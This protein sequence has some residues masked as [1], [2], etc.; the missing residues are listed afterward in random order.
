MDLPKTQKGFDS[1]FVV[2][3]KLTKVAQFLPIATIVTTLKVAELFLKRY[4]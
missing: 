1:I 4:L 2:V 3:N